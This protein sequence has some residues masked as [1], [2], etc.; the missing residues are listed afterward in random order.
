MVLQSRR[1]TTPP[2][3][4]EWGCRMADYLVRPS[5][6]LSTAYYRVRHEYACGLVAGHWGSVAARAEVG[7]KRGREDVP[8]RES[9]A[10]SRSERW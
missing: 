4:A 7:S 10:L 2:N 8:G 6:Y 5:N 9:T 1:C 3:L